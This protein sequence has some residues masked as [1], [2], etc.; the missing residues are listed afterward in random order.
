MTYGFKNW[1]VNTTIS[2]SRHHFGHYKAL[3]TFDDE[4]YK[5]LEGFNTEM[6]T[7]YNTVINTSIYLGTPLTRWKK[8]IA[9]PIENPRQHK[10]KQ[11]LT[12]R[13]I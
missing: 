5:D 11:T 12:H 2:P 6:T 1:R 7:I 13:H 8:S 10:N 4:K 9:V 3:L